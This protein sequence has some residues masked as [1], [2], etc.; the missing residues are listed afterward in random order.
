MSGAPPTDEPIRKRVFISYAREDADWARVCASLSR[1]QGHEVFLDTDSIRAGEDWPQ[2]LQAEMARADQVLLVWTGATHRSHW[3]H[4]EY[5]TALAL[6]E[7]RGDDGFLQIYNVDGSPVP[8][9]L[10][11]IQALPLPRVRPRA[12]PLVYRVGTVASVCPLLWLWLGAPGFSATALAV[13]LVLALFGLGLPLLSR[14][15]STRWMSI[16]RALIDLGTRLRTHRAR[17]VLETGAS[18]LRRLYGE[19]VLSWRTLRRAMG[20]SALAIVLCA[21]ISVWIFGWQAGLALFRKPL[22][23]EVPYGAWIIG[24]NILSD[25]VAIGVTFALLR[26]A[27][28]VEEPTPGRLLGLLVL[29][30]GLALLLTVVPILLGPMLADFVNTGEWFAGQ[31][32]TF[33]APWGEA[34]WPFPETFYRPDAFVPTAVGEWFFWHGGPLHAELFFWLQ[35]PNTILSVVGFACLCTA[36]LPTLL[37]GTTL[38]TAAASSWVFP[39]LARAM[40]ALG[41]TRGSL[42]VRLYTWLCP[43]LLFASV[44]VVATD[45]VVEA[46]PRHFAGLSTTTLLEGCRT[47]VGLDAIDQC[48]AAARRLRDARRFD[49]LQRTLNVGYA[50]LMERIPAA[51]GGVCAGADRCQSIGRET[52][53]RLSRQLA[54]GDLGLVRDALPGWDFARRY[55][56]ATWRIGGRVVPSKAAL[57]SPYL[58]AFAAAAG[59]PQVDVTL[60]RGGLVLE[61]WVFIV[62]GPEPAG[63]DRV[64]L[65]PFGDRV[66]Y[67][68]RRPLRICWSALAR[69]ATTDHD[70]IL[71]VG[72]PPGSTWRLEL[73]P[74][75]PS[76]GRYLELT[77]SVWLVGTSPMGPIGDWLPYIPAGTALS[78]RATVD[79]SGYSPF[80]RGPRYCVPTAL[81]P[82]EGPIPPAL[83]ERWIALT[84]H[85]AS[86]HTV[87]IEPGE[88]VTVRSPMTL[89]S[90]WR[91]PRALHPTDPHSGLPWFDEARVHTL[92]EGWRTRWRACG[93][94]VSHRPVGQSPLGAE[95]G[96]A[97]RLLG[98][99]WVHA[100]MRAIP[101]PARRSEGSPHTA[102]CHDVRRAGWLG[103]ESPRIGVRVVDDPPLAETTGVFVGRVIER[104]I[105]GTPLSVSALLSGPRARRGAPPDRLAIRVTRGD[106]ARWPYAPFAQSDGVEDSHAKNVNPANIA[107]PLGNLLLRRHDRI[108]AVNQMPVGDMSRLWLDTEATAGLLRARDDDRITLLIERPDPVQGPGLRAPYRLTVEYTPHPL[109]PEASRAWLDDVIGPRPE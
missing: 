50:R 29:D 76:D 56:D 25:I 57:F 74:D 15:A 9:P 81:R 38:A 30:L 4:R 54:A 34:K 84:G 10:A 21:A 55:S 17:R 71:A 83:A 79:A 44:I 40:I 103:L 61:R 106:S 6:R 70:S 28:R 62:G 46:G 75:T 33:E 31:P 39:R 41:Q 87:D 102:P 65:H 23:G 88:T 2:R 89:M 64:D 85:R 107:G 11:N 19:K 72:G 47:G 91:A 20:L 51:T 12:A 101:T 16:A 5:T 97:D 80:D 27:L 98:G 13:C 96:P 49:A 67:D 69:R 35:M 86:P 18:A 7:A 32:L 108:I 22:I 78:Y 93:Q 100:P 104:R 92:R 1:A 24:S 58:H 68:A 3:V 36:C 26:R 82:V 45:R 48:I 90:E 95:L 77:R 59:E 8:E 66:E 14:L 52:L 94:A 53:S 37:L 105:D 42:A 63:I 99:R 43:V 73:G 109:D 60:E